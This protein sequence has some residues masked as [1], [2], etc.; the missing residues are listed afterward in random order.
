MIS[1]NKLLDDAKTLEA[2]DVHLTD[3]LPPVVRINGSLRKLS[4]Y[5]DMNDSSIMEAVE[6]MVNQRQ[7]DQITS[8]KD[9]D[10]SYQS[11]SGIRH[12]VNVYH[13]RGHVAVA[14]RI[15]RNEIPTVKDLGLPQILNNFAME[16]RGLFLVT[17]PT[18]SGKS[19]TLAAMI[20]HIN[21]NKNSHIITLEDPIEY[22]HTHKQ[23]IINQRE[24]GL[25]I[26][27]FSDSLRA[28]LREDPD[29]ILVG[30]MRDFETIS[31]AITAAETGHLVLSTLH[32]VSAAET[33]NRIIDV[34]P[35]HQQGQVR[36]ELA[37]VLVGI[38]S[39]T[40]V[41]TADGNGR[42]AASEILVAN[43][44]VAAMIRENKIHMVDSAIQTGRASGMTTLDQCLAKLVKSQKITLKSA[45]YS[46]QNKEELNRYL[47]GS[48][49]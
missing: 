3:G 2:S 8:I 37:N 5:G 12:R 48:M 13:Q 29:V 22:T 14:I 36:S 44:A 40:L 6:Q 7:Y 47:S 30:E 11:A 27:N 4:L 26:E 19:T 24:V 28:S 15:L 39:Q 16:P 23:C 31:A 34:Y 10:F 32:T 18:G 42:V 38:V 25:D 1:I 17:G 43:D 21:E 46:C 45:M 33:I 9:T 41:P 20:D 35:A 49:M